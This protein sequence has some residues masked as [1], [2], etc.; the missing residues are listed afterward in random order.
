M[1]IMVLHA[2]RA[3]LRDMHKFLVE[4]A[5]VNL[6]EHAICN[7]GVYHTQHAILKLYFTEPRGF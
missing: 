1:K 2:T 6:T 3:R 5:S 7:F 4:L